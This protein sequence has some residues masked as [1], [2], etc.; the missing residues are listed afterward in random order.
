APT[1]APVA[2]SPTA[3]T[4]ASASYFQQKATLDDIH[5]DRVALERILADAKGGPIDP[6]AF[7]ML[8][9]ILN[10]TPQLRSA[11][12]EL[13]S[14]QATLR[15]ERQ[16]LTDANPRIK[17]LAEGVRVLEQETIPRIAT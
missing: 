2:A 4:P 15:T 5:S 10:N 14:R 17:Q 8:P 3:A 9:S 7:L 6:Q 1:A 16:Y 13:S 12:E 11:I